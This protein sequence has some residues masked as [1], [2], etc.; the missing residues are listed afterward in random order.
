MADFFD[1][2]PIAVKAIGGL[3]LAAYIIYEI[4]REDGELRPSNVFG[5]YPQKKFYDFAAISGYLI[6]LLIDTV[7]FPFWEFYKSDVSNHRE[8]FIIC[9]VST[10]LWLWRGLLAQGIQNR[11]ELRKE[12]L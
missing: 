3:A 9:A 6:F 8:L 4:F 1:G 11:R 5:R 7:D 10:V 12:S 2:L